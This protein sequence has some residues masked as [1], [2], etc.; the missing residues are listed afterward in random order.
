MNETHQC[1]E[2][3]C[4]FPTIEAARASETRFREIQD[5]C[6]VGRVP[7]LRQGDVIYIGT[8]LYLGHGRD[9]FRGGLA[10]V[11]EMRMEKSK[12]Q[13]APFVRVLQQMDTIH[14]WKLLASE[15]RELRQR[16]GKEWAHPDPD[17]RTEFNDW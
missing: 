13:Q 10:E 6:A 7:E 2:T 14:N 5:A 15:Q 8:E 12:G 17:N 3:G 9:D 16:H 4:S 11:S 1:T